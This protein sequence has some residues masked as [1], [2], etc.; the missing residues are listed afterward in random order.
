MPREG[1]VPLA[2]A[3]LVACV[4]EAS[5]PA[6]S[7]TNVYPTALF[8]C[9]SSSVVIG[10]ELWAIGDGTS[11]ARV[12]STVDGKNWRILA[13]SVPCVSHGAPLVHDNKVWLVGKDEVWCTTNGVD[14]SK[15]LSPVPFG[16]RVNCGLFPS[17]GTS[18]WSAGPYSDRRNHH[19]RVRY[20]ALPDGEIWEKVSDSAPWPQR[21]TVRMVVYD[22]RMWMVGGYL[23]NDVW[24]SSD[25]INWT[26]ATSSAPWA[27]R[28]NPY[29]FVHDNRLWLLRGY[30]GDYE[31]TT[32][33]WYTTDG[34]TWTY[35]GK[36][37]PDGAYI[38]GAQ[39]FKGQFYLFA[40]G[41]FYRSTNGTDWTN[42]YPPHAIVRAA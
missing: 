36:A 12:W 18:G 38:Y 35:A 42:I 10:G 3:L 21:A 29:L 1:W 16:Y 7:W 27:P 2:V 28:Y 37:N 30:D 41:H 32:D 6:M 5:E 23:F 15:K 40:S 25:G 13:E 8:S 4:G 11:K 34:A 24:F 20:L 14:W 19:S 9:P 39:E 31:D 22:N 17:T 33:V 26:Q